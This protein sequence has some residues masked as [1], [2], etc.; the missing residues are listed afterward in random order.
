[1]LGVVAI[2][3]TVLPQLSREVPLPAPLWVIVLASLAQSAVLVALAVWAGVAFAPVVNFRAPVFEVAATRRALAPALRPQLIPG[4]GAGMLGGVLLFATLRYAPAALAGV[5]ERF[6][7]P[8][9]ARVLYGGITEELLLRWGLMTTLVWLTWRFL[10]RR[11]GAPR[12]G[13]VWLAIA[14]SALVFGAGH[15]PV[16]ATLIGDLPANVVAFVV[17]ANAAFG[18][19]FGYLFWRS[20]LESAMMAHALAHVV[21]YLI[22]LT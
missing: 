21:N 1:M 3:A 13:Y 10:Q 2:T 7:V 6:N 15:L 19:L 8:L 20:G 22:T 9:F 5:Q 4:L 17:G 16:A 12:A 11:Q 18:V 14:V